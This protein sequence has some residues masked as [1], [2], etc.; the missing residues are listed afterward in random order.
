MCSIEV[1]QII[2]DDIIEPIFKVSI[3]EHHVTD[4]HLKLLKSIEATFSGSTVSTPYDICEIIPDVSNFTITL[5]TKGDFASQHKSVWLVVNQVG[6]K[7]SEMLELAKRQHVLPWVGAALELSS[8]QLECVGRIFCV[9]PLP[10]EDRAPF[11][12]HVNGTFAIS[13]NRRSLNWEAQEK[14]GDEEGL[15]NKLLVSKH[16]PSCYV[17]LIS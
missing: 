8:S 12:V 16:L 9:L 6:S 2:A 13:K 17:S 11:C 4:R 15:W 5:L 10:V 14:Q 7:D 3:D 1:S